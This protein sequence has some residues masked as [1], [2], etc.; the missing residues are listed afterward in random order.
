MISSKVSRPT[1][2]DIKLVLLLSF[3]HTIR[4]A[5]IQINV[6]Y[7]TAEQNLDALKLQFGVANTTALVA[8][9]IRSGIIK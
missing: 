4:E 1:E 5:A 8:S 6:G 2:R 9:F 3:G 7:R